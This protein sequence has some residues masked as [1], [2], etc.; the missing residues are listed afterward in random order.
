MSDDI[1]K[2]QVQVTPCDNDADR[3]AVLNRLA[4]RFLDVSQYDKSR[5][6]AR[7]ALELAERRND[8]LDFSRVEAGKLSLE[9]RP[10][11]LRE[12]VENAV[13]FTA[14]G[15]SNCPPRERGGAPWKGVH[16]LF[17]RGHRDRYPEGETDNHLRPVCPG[18]RFRDAEA[19]DS[20]WPYRHTWLR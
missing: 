6:F 19:R 12:R 11:A 5:T 9:H 16:P 1:E 2:L 7:Q 4:K 15:H 18:R 14:K 20:G 13:K 17:R 8:V 3:R 10:F